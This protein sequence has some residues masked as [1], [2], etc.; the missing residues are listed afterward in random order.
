MNIPDSCNGTSQ[1]VQQL[2]VNVLADLGPNEDNHKKIA[3]DR[4]RNIFVV[5]YDTN[6]I[7]RLHSNGTVDCVV[8]SEC[9]EVK[10]PLSICFDKIVTNFIWIIRIQLLYM[11]IYVNDVDNPNLI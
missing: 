1:P 11:C 6:T 3:I 9:E 2:T 7:Q 5:G 8:L 4:N 10:E